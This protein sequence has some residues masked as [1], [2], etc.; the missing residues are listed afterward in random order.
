MEGYFYYPLSMVL[1]LTYSLFT[2]TREQYDNE[3]SLQKSICVEVSYVDFVHWRPSHPQ[4]TDEVYRALQPGF[5]WV[6]RKNLHGETF[7]EEVSQKDIVP[8]DVIVIHRGSC[9]MF[10]DAVI[11]KGR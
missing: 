5:V 3:K 10:V 6:K 2:D 7:I 11:V 9:R 1:V 8:G 4:E